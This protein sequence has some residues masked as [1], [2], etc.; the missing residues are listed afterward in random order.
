M[1]DAF[2]KYHPGV[3]FL[4]F[5]FIFGFSMVFMH[6]MT[7]LISL[8]GSIIYSIELKGKKAVKFN[9]IIL[10]PVIMVTSLINPIFNHEGATILTYLPS[11]NPLTLESIVYGLAASTMLGTVFTWFTSFNVIMTSD[12]FVYLFGRMIPGLSLIL[13]MSLRFVPKF[14]EQVKVVSEAQ[15]SIGRD[16]SRGGLFERIGHGMAILSIMITWALEN[17]IETADSMKSR[18]YGLPGRTAFLIYRFDR[19]DKKALTAILFLGSYILI[20][21]LL[22]GLE[23]YYFPMMHG[24]SLGLYSISLWL[25]YFL[26]CIVPIIANRQEERQWKAT[27]SKI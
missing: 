25:A 12:K 23:W 14:K 3:N 6:P 24:A 15:R 17:S 5:S 18:G 16:I 10:L 21:G 7:L 2:S 20:G 26:L 11:G 22:G 9:F 19:R 4:Y 13:S 27:R 1:E 8:A